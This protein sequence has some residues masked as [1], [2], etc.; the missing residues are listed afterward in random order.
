VSFE[1]FE[2]TLRAH[3]ARHIGKDGVA[4]IGALFNGEGERR[5]SDEHVRAVTLVL[6]DFDMLPA[7][8]EEGVRAALPWRGWCYT[9]SSHGDP[10]ARNPRSGAPKWL[11]GTV[12]LRFVF[13]L[14]THITERP[15][16]SV[17]VLAE[18]L[19]ERL[20]EG[21]GDSF[22][23]GATRASKLAYTPRRSPERAVLPFQLEAL[24]GELLDAETLG[25]SERLA[26]R[27]RPTRGAAPRAAVTLA[28]APWLSDA[29]KF[30]DPNG[31][32]TWVNMGMA[33]KH[34]LGD[35]AFP[36]WC[37][38]AMEAD[39]PDDLAG[40]QYRWEGLKPTG[41]I[42]LAS[43]FHAARLAGWVAPAELAAQWA[44]VADPTCGAERVPLEDARA[45]LAE[46]LEDAWNA[47]CVTLLAVTPGV[48][49]T[50]S[51]L[52][53]LVSEFREYRR[54]GGH[55]LT[56]YTLPTDELCREK[57]AEFLELADRFVRAGHLSAADYN[58][59]CDLVLYESSRR[60]EPGHPMHCPEFA[61]FRA[62]EAAWPGEGGKFCGLCPLNVRN[63]A[64]PHACPASRTLA[65]F[66]AKRPD[67]YLIFRTHHM[68]AARL[69]Q[70]ER[71]ISEEDRAELGSALR[72][73]R[74]AQVL[75][76]FAF[77][78]EAD[79]DGELLDVWARATRCRPI[80]VEHRRQWWIQVT[81]DVRRGV[82]PP[83]LEAG[84]HVV[85][86]FDDEGE[87]V[88]RLTASGRRAVAAWCV[89]A[90]GH[91][92]PSDPL[93]PVD[94]DD[95]TP[96]LWCVFNEPD[97]R[98]GADR[99]ILDEALGSAVFRQVGVSFEDLA[100]LEAQGVL[101]DVAARDP[102]AQGGPLARLHH[103][104]STQ[105]TRQRDGVTEP[106]GRVQ[107][108][109]EVVPGGLAGVALDWGRFE[110]VQKAALEAGQP[111][112]FDFEQG[113]ALKALLERGGECAAG[114]HP[115]EGLSIWVAH[116]LRS[117]STPT[118]I[119]LDA[120]AHP[121][122]LTWAWP[123]LVTHQIRAELP[124]VHTVR[125]EAELGSAADLEDGTR[126]DALAR[127]RALH[128]THGADVPGA[129]TLHAVR[130]LHR[131][132]LHS[133]PS[134]PR[135]FVRALRDPEARPITH[136]GGPDARGSNAYEHCAGVV[137]DPW[138]VPGATLRGLAQLLE[139]LHGGERS[140]LE[141]EAL[142]RL[143]LEAAP[144]IQLLHRVRPA[145][146]AGR[147]LVYCGRL[148]LPGLPSSRVVTRGELD[149][150]AALRGDPLAYHNARA[151]GHLVRQTVEAHGGLW[152]VSF[153]VA[154]LLG[155]V[156]G[157]ADRAARPVEWPGRAELAARL[158]AL[159]WSASTLADAAG[160][161]FVEVESGAQGSPLR[162]LRPEGGPELTRE[163]VEADA[164]DA[165]AHWFMWE[166]ERVGLV[167]PVRDVLADFEELPT[168][169]QVADA[170]GTSRRAT[171]RDAAR[172]GI[173]GAAELADA[174]RAARPL[175]SIPLPTP[176][177]S[178]E[179]R[180]TAPPRRRAF[181]L[182]VLPEI[183]PTPDERR[184]WRAQRDR[185]RRT[186][187]YCPHTRA[188]MKWFPELEAWTRRAR[189]NAC[190]VDWPEELP[191]ELAA[192]QG[193]RTL[194]TL[195]QWHPLTPT[196]PDPNVDRPADIS[197]IPMPA[198][199]GVLAAVATLD[200][201][202]TRSVAALATMNAPA[203]ER[204]TTSIRA[205]MVQERAERR[206]Q[207]LERPRLDPDLFTSVAELATARTLGLDIMPRWSA[208]RAE[209]LATVDAATNAPST[210]AV[211]LE[212]H[213]RSV[214]EAEAFE[215]RGALRLAPRDFRDVAPEFPDVQTWARRRRE[216]KCVV[217]WP[218]GFEALPLGKVGAKLRGDFMSYHPRAGGY[219][220]RAGRPAPAP[221]PP[222]VEIVAD[223]SEALANL[224]TCGLE[225]PS[226]IGGAQVR[227]VEAPPHPDCRFVAIG[228]PRFDSSDER[229]PEAIGSGPTRRA[230]L[231]DMVRRATLRGPTSPGWDRDLGF[232][233]SA[234]GAECPWQDAYLREREQGTD[235]GRVTFR[236]FML[237]LWSV[238]D[239]V[240][241]CPT[242]LHMFREQVLTELDRV[243]FTPRMFERADPEAFQPNTAPW[244]CAHWFEWVSPEDDR[245]VHVQALD[246]DHERPSDWIAEIAEVYE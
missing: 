100:M 179:T 138:Y 184:Q 117:E 234:P 2:A 209:H 115:R 54:N 17:R 125:V 168:W 155:S 44:P 67:A 128:T 246:A 70:G 110:G 28:D 243:I 213:D 139:H 156:A 63:G 242:E 132:S 65:E 94:A 111:A 122:M 197:A 41:A 78:Y 46:R 189:A 102:G 163:R 148:D 45:A 143:E 201:N 72:Q 33:I 85:L 196:I 116:T 62:R 14:A 50:Y 241:A 182:G 236:E 183:T 180:T 202:P 226:G 39:D 113:E 82:A 154:E 19:A 1:E 77:D 129:P 81:R 136:P 26:A 6:L 95:D 204:L 80:V 8:L 222:I 15:V 84:E 91:D 11:P 13:P 57:L 105:P 240:G 18:L 206:H 98:A 150:Y 176:A 61:T 23:A 191:A 130:S 47:H 121:D 34:D 137:V 108:L 157:F 192:H 186:A 96:W 24:G 127:H 174:W 210:P 79:E 20:P 64:G 177:P 37:E 59:L 185:W 220:G 221:R 149:I 165:G 29:L 140:E 35:D 169:Q 205:E 4:L 109:G 134:P 164:R 93:A 175:K 86:G 159:D 172:E 7:H 49:K 97:V 217:D 32:D 230:A 152:R 219:F 228:R 166:G 74:W 190:V 75:R 120:T 118:T 145:I 203:P 227:P 68:H 233:V 22:D 53:R 223:I 208:K 238:A 104:A 92:A 181:R 235:C 214:H 198:V 200:V 239:P 107:V 199:G 162:Y 146:Y 112:P 245:T 158:D 161:A 90:R 224:R 124:D 16:E 231:W 188:M 31:R 36:V 144:L 229:Q 167:P 71:G 147:T 211:D 76:A 119:L 178:P 135:D 66:A 207:R 170:R 3:A 133:E 171:Q 244:D 60:H 237:G 194:A 141:C 51:A 25:L 21:V 151:V 173:R 88:L 10:E 89:E 69:A 103:W 48:G 43:V 142:A 193:G 99:A 123:D 114:V 153:E 40:Q 218:E 101:V 12:N 232:W 58:A 83:E 52:R 27:A 73:V 56:V 215:W 160:V 187:H 216:G 42:T 126:P 131:P 5:R 195:R 30:I 106:H 9:T 87:E 212:D 55:K 225:A 38:W